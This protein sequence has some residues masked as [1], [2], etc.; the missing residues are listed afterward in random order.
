[1]EIERLLEDGGW[2]AATVASQGGDRLIKYM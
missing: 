2:G 1:M